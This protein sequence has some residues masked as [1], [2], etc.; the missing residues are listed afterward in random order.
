MYDLAAYLVSLCGQEKP[1]DN[2]QADNIITLSNVDRRVTVFTPCFFNS[3][4]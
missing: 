3:L 1:L 2:G 4:P